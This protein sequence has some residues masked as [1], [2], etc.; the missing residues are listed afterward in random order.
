MIVPLHDFLGKQTLFKYGDEGQHVA[1]YSGP[2]SAQRI[3]IALGGLTD[4][5]LAT[6][7]TQPLS[8]LLPTMGWGMV[9]SR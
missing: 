8:E 2:A 7:Y 9:R 1:L 6:P 4:G 5:M 3:V